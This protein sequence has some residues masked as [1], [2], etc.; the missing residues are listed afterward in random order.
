MRGKQSNSIHTNQ[1]E[2]YNGSYSAKVLA[3]DPQRYA[4]RVLFLSGY[5]PPV[6]VRVL[7]DGPC[8]ALRIRQHPLPLPGST[9]LVCFANGDIRSG[10]WIGAFPATLFDAITTDQNNSDATF[11]SGNVDY[12]SD[13]SGFWSLRDEDGNEIIVWPDGTTLTIGSPPTTRY[14]HTVQPNSAQQINEVNQSDIISSVPAPFPIKLT[15]PTG[16][17]FSMDSSGNVA[18]TVPAN[19]TISLS[20]GDSTYKLVD[21]R[22]ITLFNEHTHTDSSGNQTS[23]PTQQAAV[24][25]QTTTATLA[26]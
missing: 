1:T 4:V 24:G 19:S 12:T 17:I 16:M 3:Q 20:D 11:Q 8:D 18:L 7:V 15:S 23:V 6:S 21:Q 10:F 25:S 5:I 2:R 13:Y 9:G 22:M 14:N 26:G